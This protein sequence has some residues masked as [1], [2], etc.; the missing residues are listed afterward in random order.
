MYHPAAYHIATIASD[1]PDSWERR[2]EA[3]GQE[4][5]ERSKE[6]EK[7]RE[8]G[9]KWSTLCKFEF[10]CSHISRLLCCK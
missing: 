10:D 4:W 9:E 3:E 8:K 6:V 7:R 5:T 1:I 2:R